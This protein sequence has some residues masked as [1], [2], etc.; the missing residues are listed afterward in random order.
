MK[1]CVE[2]T[3]MGLLW[4]VYFA[5][6]WTFPESPIYRGFLVFC[7]AGGSTLATLILWLIV[8]RGEI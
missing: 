7:A 8:K 6:Y 3:I 2:H 1:S 4:L 5:I